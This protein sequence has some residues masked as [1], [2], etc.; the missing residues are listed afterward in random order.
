[1]E[2]IMLNKISHAQ[3]DIYHVIFHTYKNKNPSSP[4]QNSDH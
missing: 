4:N 2:V 3:E 1:M